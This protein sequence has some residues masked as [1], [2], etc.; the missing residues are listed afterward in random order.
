MSDDQT[1]DE[2]PRGFLDIFSSSADTPTP[3]TDD[4]EPSPTDQAEDAADATTPEE[5]QDDGSDLTAEERVAANLAASM[6]DEG[7]AVAEPA[8]QTAEAEPLP[9]GEIDLESLTPEQLRV[10]AEEAIKLRAEVSTKD[11][12]RVLGEISAAEQQAAGLWQ[13]AEARAETHY[14][15]E[16][17]KRISNARR[18]AETRDDGDAYFEAEVDRQR[19]LVEQAKRAWLMEQ[20]QDLEAQLQAYRQEQLKPFYARQLVKE[21]G[22]PAS[23]VKEL[24]DDPGLPWQRY[25]KR[26][27]E[28]KAMRDIL[29]ENQTKA[30]QK[31]RAEG[32]KRLIETAVVVPASGRAKPFKRKAYEGTAAEGLSIIKTMSKMRS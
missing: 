25:P 28:L 15:A 11:E 5:D 16:L 4:T 3:D 9:E 30:D 14:A 29:A 23:A 27:D 22:L 32:R 31:V 21:A 26:I 12:Q 2:G 7:V 17:R 1:V 13:S 24:L 19:A 18:Q 8:E 20:G 10:L 6:E